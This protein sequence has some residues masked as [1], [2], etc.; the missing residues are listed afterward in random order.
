[1]ANITFWNNALQHCQPH[2]WGPQTN[3]SFSSMHPQILRPPTVFSTAIQMWLMVVSILL[4]P[5]I[6]MLSSRYRVK[7]ASLCHRALAW[8]LRLVRGR[9]CVR[10]THAFVFSKCT[11]G[12]ADSVLETFNLYGDTHPSLCIG[13]QIGQ[14]A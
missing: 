3:L 13:P 9:V 2:S 11:H 6:I 4:F 1:M 8:T 14:Y 12:N 7:V 10:S 5:A